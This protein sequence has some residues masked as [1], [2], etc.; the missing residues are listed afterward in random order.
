MH[1]LPC[2]FRIA[3]LDRFEDRG[4]LLQRKRYRV[5]Q[6]QYLG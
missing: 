3:T 2:G 4:V 5:G 1:S 6:K